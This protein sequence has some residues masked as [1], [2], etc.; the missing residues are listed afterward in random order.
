MKRLGRIACAESDPFNSLCMFLISTK[1][2]RFNHTVGMLQIGCNFLCHFA[3]TIF[4]DDIIIVI[5]VVIYSNNISMSFFY[6][7]VY[8]DR[9]KQR[10]TIPVICTASFV[11]A[12]PPFLHEGTMQR[13]HTPYPADVLKCIEVY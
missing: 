11:P 13:Y 1:H 10:K 7:L 8:K 9:T 3:G 6:R 2:N 5:R 4:Y 12:A